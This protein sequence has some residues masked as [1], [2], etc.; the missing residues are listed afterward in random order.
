[1][2]RYGDI[3]AILSK[4]QLQMI[5]ESDVDWRAMH[6]YSD[7]L[8]N[9]QGFTLVNTYGLTD[10]TQEYLFNGHRYSLE[11]F[12]S[13]GDESI[14]FNVKIENGQIPKCFFEAADRL[15]KIDITKY[16]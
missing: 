10:M 15:L 13:Y 2:L 8:T 6:L 1:M 3:S 11:Y 5:I 7:C 4:D 16:K 9:E 14:F 12:A